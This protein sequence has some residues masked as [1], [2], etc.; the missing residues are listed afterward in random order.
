MPYSINTRIGVTAQV[1]L[2]YAVK[3]GEL[4]ESL[5]VSRHRLVVLALL[6]GLDTAAEQVRAEQATKAAKPSRTA[7]KE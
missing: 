1:P 5:K 6:A 7:V 2:D 4:A 3:L